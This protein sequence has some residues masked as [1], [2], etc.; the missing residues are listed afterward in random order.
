MRRFTLLAVLCLAL[1]GCG[2]DDEE[3]GGGG[4]A[5]ATPAA[6]STPEAAPGG[7]EQLQLAAP[8]DG[9]LTFD[10]TEL[11]AKAGT[12]TIDF[13]NPSSTPHAVEIEGGGV[14]EASD[15]VS[16]GRT[17]V[18]AELEPGEYTFYCPVGNH[19]DGG[20]EGTLTVE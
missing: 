11:T 18:T 8:A 9:S 17:S 3:S 10:K 1:A 4:A 16:A 6:E 19:R 13:D 5:T 20:M 15:T 2:S 14:E 7:G 12:V